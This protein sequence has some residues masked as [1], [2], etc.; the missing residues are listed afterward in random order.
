MPEVRI[1]HAADLH[2]DWPFTG[3]GAGETKSRLRREE[4]KAVLASIID[5]A[6]R[7]QAEVVLLAGDLFEHAYATRGTMQFMDEQFGRLRDVPVFIS[8][9]NHDP[10]VTGSYYETFP[11]APNVHIFGPE[12]ERVD[13]KGLPV[14]VRGWGFPAWEVRECQ[15][16][17]F[18]P[19]DPQRINLVVV[20]GG[21]GAY[22]PMAPQDLAGLGA[23]YIAL[24]HIHKEGVV[25]EQAGRVIARYSGSPEALGF[26]EPGEH[27]VILGTVGKEYSRLNFVPV[28]R[29]RYLTAN[30]DVTGAVSLEE[31]AAA[32][33]RVASPADRQQHG[34]RL[35]LTGAVD[36]GLRVDIPVLQEQLSAE[37][38]VLKL[39]DG[40]APDVDLELIARER[41]ARGLFVQRLL[42]ME[43][44]ETDPARRRVVRRALAHGLAAFAGKG[45]AR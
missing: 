39:A 11:W 3:L 29:R 45:G 5:L 28:G 38:F 26:G 20:H 42:A 36:P 40:T 17:R 21:D 9:G 32:I 22:H 14:T 18:P 23:D 24:G 41:S 43:Q 7:E 16:R 25:L 1:L 6:I 4:L 30:V 33:R 44:A 15:L 8:P 35:T 27:G 31:L 2:L 10:Y 19:P 13:L 37:F 12:P 34:Y